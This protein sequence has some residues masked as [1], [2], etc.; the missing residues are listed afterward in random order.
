MSLCKVPNMSC[1]ALYNKESM[2]NIISLADIANDHRVTIDTSKDKAMFVHLPD[3]IIR[4]RQMENWLYGLSLNNPKHHLTKEECNKI[5]NDDIPALLSL[6][7]DG[8]D[9][10]DDE[11]DDSHL[12]KYKYKYKIDHKGKLKTNGRKNKLKIKTI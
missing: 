10:L 2:T 4:F 6:N 12:G 11:Y 5:F 1:K 7:E 9:S 8:Y 3:K